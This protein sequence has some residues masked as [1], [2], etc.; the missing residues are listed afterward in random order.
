MVYALRNLEPKPPFGVAAPP[1]APAVADAAKGAGAA[2]GA[3]TRAATLAPATSR[4]LQELAE[5]LHAAQSRAEAA[6]A[7]G[8][9][10]VAN[11][12]APPA[13]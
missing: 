2:A 1:P 12:A 13:P 6:P 11:A 4:A 5:F 8:E 10:G 3:P 7:P 9:T